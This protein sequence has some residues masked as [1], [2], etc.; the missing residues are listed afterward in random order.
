MVLEFRKDPLKGTLVVVANER[1]LRPSDPHFSCPFCKGAEKTTPPT[2]LALPNEKKWVIRCF[3]NA[4]AIVKPRGKFKPPKD[5]DFF[6]TSPAYGEHEVIV[7][8]PDHHQLFFEIK[9][10]AH[11]AMIFKAYQER[12]AVLSKRKATKY[13]HL[14]KNHGRQAGA[15]IEHEHSQIISLPMV[16]ENV[17][18]EIDNEAAY[19]KKHGKCLI[20]D[21]LT[22]ESVNIILQNESFTVLCPSFARFPFEAWIISR[23]HKKSITDFNEFEG[24]QYMQVLRTAIEAVSG[25]SRD[26]NIVYHNGIAGEDSHFHA[27]I[28]PRPNVWAGL[29]LG[30]GII[31]NT[32]TE[33]ESIAALA[34]SPS[35]TCWA[36]PVI[37]GKKKGKTVSN[38]KKKLKIK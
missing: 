30:T 11:L 18:K 36:R 26:Y 31:V 24:S 34:C 25:V 16:P 2:K 20:C 5:C 35:G 3:D 7:E 12:F 4:F 9:D 8:S 29:E 27:E 1:A 19:K 32:K 23:E 13:V 28:Y 38:K 10:P 17:Q 21:L 33:K 22:R 6:Y 14:F 15:S 37:T